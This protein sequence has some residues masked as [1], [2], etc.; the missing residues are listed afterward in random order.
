MPAPPL[1]SGEEISAG[2]ARRTMAVRVDLGLIS[3]GHLMSDVYGS[4]LVT[5]LPVW[6]RLF[7][8]PFS[9][10]GFLVFL[11]S[12][13]LAVFEPAGGYLADRRAERWFLLGLLLVA[14]SMSAVGLAPSYP[15]LVILVLA[16]TAGQSLFG[17]Q[18]TS[19][20]TRLSGSARG[21][22]VSIFL[23]GGALGA[24]VGPI[25]VAVLVSVLGLRQTWLMVL[26]GLLLVAVLYWRHLPT[27]A[28]SP[29]GA[30]STGLA[31]LMRSGAALALA[32]VLLIRG[33]TETGILAFLPI[34]VQEKGGNLM[35]AGAVVS[36]FKLSGAAGAIVGGFLSDRMNW[37]PILALSFVLSAALLYIFLQSEGIVALLLVALL[38]ATLLSSSAY[39][40]VIAQNMLP[41]RSSTAA[42]LVFSISILGGGLGALAEGLL[43]DR[44]GVEAALLALGL[45]LP[46]IGVA[47]TLGIREQAAERSA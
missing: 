22:G 23:A 44:F 6:L 24:A 20:A 35:A 26:P 47:V 30:G 21:L 38:G 40:Q 2:E 36:L 4:F 43:A 25:S 1:T 42:G 17:P 7:D 29:R 32:A 13:G 16:S 46:L 5:L 9:G 39:T 37:K 19:M 3:A 33:A 28:G 10:A 34:L 27:P 41:G 31:A 8:L 45:V 15:V 11:R 18:A 14:V 12:A